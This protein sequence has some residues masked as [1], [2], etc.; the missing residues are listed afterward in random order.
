MCVP[1]C[2]QN[3][4]LFYVLTVS[5]VWALT[6]GLASRTWQFCVG[7]RPPP[8]ASHGTTQPGHRPCMALRYPWR[9][10]RGSW[11][12]VTKKPLQSCASPLGCTLSSNISSG[13]ERKT[14]KMEH[15]QVTREN[16]ALRGSKPDCRLWSKLPS[17]AYP[18]PPSLPL[19]PFLHPQLHPDWVILGEALPLLKLH[20]FF[21]TQT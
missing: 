12:L 6:E 15:S 8:G 18:R 4:G 19:P 2:P 5:T 16:E 20:L 17:S 14:K 10:L 11:P 7:P 9:P 13:P 3:L 1:G 21:F